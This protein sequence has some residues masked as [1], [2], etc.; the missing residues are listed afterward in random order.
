M[1][2]KCPDTVSIRKAQLFKTARLIDEAW[3]IPSGFS[4]GE[5]V[6][7]SFLRRFWGTNVFQ[8]TSQSGAIAAISDLQLERFCLYRN[9]PA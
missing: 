8:C 7:V 3:E 6:A 9:R 5:F 4:P 2:H 1:K